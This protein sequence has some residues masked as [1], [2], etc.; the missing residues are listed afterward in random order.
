MNEFTPLANISTFCAV[1]TVRW[2]VVPPLG[3]ALLLHAEVICSRAEGMYERKKCLV[4]SKAKIII[5][6]VRK[7]AR[8]NIIQAV[9]LQ[10]QY[11]PILDSF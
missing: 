8:R 9:I 6:I 4:T 7:A 3:L 11:T 5:I 2:L 10:T 1:A